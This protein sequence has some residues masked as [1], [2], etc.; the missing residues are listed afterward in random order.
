MGSMIK[1]IL[2]YLT[3]KIWPKYPSLKQFIK[4]GFAGIL[5]TLTDFVVYFAVTRLSDWFAEFYL[6][7]NAISFCAAVT[8][9]FFINKYWTFRNSDRN[10]SA[11]QYFKFFLANLLTLLINQLILYMLVDGLGLHD[12]FG[13]VLIIITYVM[14]NFALFKYWVF[15]K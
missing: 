5:N 7:A 9:S 12:L 14:M 10:K 13:K 1:S 3:D 4:Y 15:K 11:F 8:Q 6:L 2:G